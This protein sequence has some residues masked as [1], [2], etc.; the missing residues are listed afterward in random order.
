[1]KKTLFF[2]IILTLV[3]SAGCGKPPQKKDPQIA[4]DKENLSRRDPKPAVVL[5]YGQVREV[6]EFD[7]V[8]LGHM[9][10]E[11][12]LL[13]VIVRYAGG[14]AEHSFELL[15]V[16]DI[17]MASSPVQVYTFLSHDAKQDACDEEVAEVLVF[18][19]SP[20][21]D[22][23]PSESFV[24]LDKTINLSFHDKDFYSLNR[25]I[26]Y[27]MNENKDMFLEH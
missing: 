1:M 19:L 24:W 12:N 2:F 3:S 14:C 4:E 11:D 13:F 23:K 21:K 15:T 25:K 20:L 18:D 6:K 8:K 7:P 22:I 9:W 27:D 17:I 26:Y 16:G 5:K 10:I